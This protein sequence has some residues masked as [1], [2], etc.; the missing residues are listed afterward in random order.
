MNT[1]FFDMQNVA[2]ERPLS[3]MIVEDI[4][5]NA[6]INKNYLLRCGANVTKMAK[7]GEEAVNNYKKLA[8]EGKKIDLICMDIEMPVMNGKDA[9]KKIRKIE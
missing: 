2:V 1:S 9:A 6:E 8:S 5:F 3:V 4:A 7:N